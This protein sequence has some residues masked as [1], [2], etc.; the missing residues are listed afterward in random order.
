M[1]P[2]QQILACTRRRLELKRQQIC[3]RGLGGAA[4]AQPGLVPAQA[5]GIKARQEVKKHV[6]VDAVAA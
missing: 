1:S 4:Q 5:T 3:V 2:G 6:P